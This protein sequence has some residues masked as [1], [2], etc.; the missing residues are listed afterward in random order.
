MENWGSM[1][2]MGKNKGHIPIRK[3]ISCGEKRTKN[4]LIRLALD[5]EGHLVRDDAGKRQ[6]RGAYV[7][8]MGSCQKQLSKNRRLNRLFRTGRGISVSPALLGE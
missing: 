7:C 8:K 2:L 4:E 6:C 5:T 1:L 3:C